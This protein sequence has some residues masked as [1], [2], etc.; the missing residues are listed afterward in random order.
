MA[1]LKDFTTQELT[2]ELIRRLQERKR[3]LEKEGGEEMEEA[4]RALDLAIKYLH[5]LSRPTHHPRPRA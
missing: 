5:P 3:R 2:Q 1:N 4:L